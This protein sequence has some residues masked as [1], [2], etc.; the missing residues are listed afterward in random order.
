MSGTN[1]Y[2]QALGDR[3][4]VATMRATADRIEAL[5]ASWSP[6]DFE[7]TYAPGKWTARQILIH[8]AHSEMAMG[9]RARMGATEANYKAQSFNQD[10][11]LAKEQTLDARVAVAAFLA[12]SRMNSAWAAS[13]S[14]ADLA[15]AVEHPAYGPVDVQWVIVAMAGHQLSHLKQLEQI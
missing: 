3:D 11:W 13:L 8:L 4:P 15:A 5:T 1:P 6:A 12:M 10:S 9:H 7:R 14:A 2:A